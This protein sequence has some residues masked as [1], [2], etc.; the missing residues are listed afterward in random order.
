MEEITVNFPASNIADP[1]GLGEPDMD[2]SVRRPAWDR[3][4]LDQRWRFRTVIGA[5]VMCF[6][7]GCIFAPRAMQ[8]L[9]GCVAVSRFTI[10]IYVCIM[11][12]RSSSEFLKDAGI[13]TETKTWH[14]IVILPTYR[15]SLEVTIQTLQSLRAQRTSSLMTVVVSYEAR[16]PSVDSNVDQLTA[17][18]GDGCFE[19]FVCLIH[20][21]CTG[22]E[23]PG[24]GSNYVYAARWMAQ[25]IIDGGRCIDDF[26]ITVCDGDVIFHPK[27]FDSFLQQLHECNNVH[28]TLWQGLMLYDVSGRGI[29]TQ[30]VS[31]LRTCAMVLCES[32]PPNPLGPATACN[33]M[34]T[35]LR[36]SLAADFCDPS[37]VNDDFNLFYRC[38]LVTGGHLKVRVTRTPCVTDAVFGST[39]W[40]ELRQ[41]WKQEYRWTAGTLVQMDMVIKEGVKYM[42]FARFSLFFCRHMVLTISDRVTVAP[43]IIAFL[44]SLYK[45][46][47]NDSNSQVRAGERD[48]TAYMLTVMTVVVMLVSAV[49]Q[50]T[51]V[52][53]KAYASRIAPAS[54][55]VDAAQCVKDVAFLGLGALFMMVCGLWA[56]VCT[57]FDRRQ[58]LTFVASTTRGTA[59]VETAAPGPMRQG[60]A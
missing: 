54:L 16:S 44:L 40:G 26:T 43:L 21:A 20:P 13:P 1:A 37:L 58:S 38:L 28:A 17:Q 49:V 33:T 15:E 53:V 9:V 59:S 22:T 3:R 46:I 55:R 2:D 7:M 39:V 52:A 23:I 35:S 8:F 4:S 31:S 14:H 5:M 29:V 57:Y 48:V 19:E 32:F 6:S 41:L 10:L 47:S 30:A 56:I 18:F 11:W 24:R 50:L 12:L 36:L 45:N 42:G 27:H 60:S 25:K 51:V 34:S